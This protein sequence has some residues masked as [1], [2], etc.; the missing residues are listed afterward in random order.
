[1]SGAEYIM[2]IMPFVMAMATRPIRLSI[3]FV[4]LVSQII[5]LVYTRTHYIREQAVYQPKYLIWG[6]AEMTLLIPLIFHNGLS[7]SLNTVPELTCKQTKST[8]GTEG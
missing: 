1:M 2:L 5:F 6:L 3:K 8:R 7:E 4:L